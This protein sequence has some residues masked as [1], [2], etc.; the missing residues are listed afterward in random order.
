L[1]PAARIAAA[2]EII[3]EIGRTR[4]AADEVVRRWGKDHRF[5]G[6]KDRKAIAE[7]VFVAL[8]GRAQSAWRME[9]DDGRALM[10]GA[11]AG[12]FDAIDALF[13]GEGHG[14]PPPTPAERRNLQ[15]NLDTAPDHVQAG[16]PEWLAASLKSRFGADWISETRAAI[17]PRA[18]VDLRVNALSG[19]VAGA[20]KLLEYEGVAPERML[21]SAY[22]LRLPPGFAT[23]VH[24]LK[25]FTTGW[26]E[27]QDEASQVAASL[28][29][30]RPGDLVVDYCAGGGGK[31][32]ALAAAMGGV[33][34]LVAADVDPR[35]LGAL[36]ERARRARARIER[37]VIG[38]AGQ[39]MEDLQAGA[40]LVFVDAPCSGSGTW[41]RHPEAAWRLDRQSISRLA[42]LQARILGQ[43]ADLV[44]PGGRLVY[45]TCSLLAEE[46][47]A[48]SRGFLAARDDFRPACITAA[49]QVSGLTEGGRLRLAALADSGHTLQF[50]PRRTG[51]D[52]FFVA[53]FKRIASP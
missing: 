8:R 53:L 22:G 51:T 24:S 41:R 9:A 25:A 2:I 7:H 31:S 39:G 6:S 34:R 29:R 3:D 37:R 11:L 4:G 44:R 35:R 19:D 52:G 36:D 28:A 26:I 10:L 32:L 20:L 38:P 27:V 16:A 12:D 50:T 13:S 21:F 30:A 33:G 14:P 49:A 47:D 43:A 42:T 1:T 15:R 48:V 18:P 45:A 46:N 40:D 23:D 5:A 17:L